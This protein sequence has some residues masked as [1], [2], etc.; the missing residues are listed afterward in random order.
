MKI[1]YLPALSAVVGVI[2]WNL[3][4]DSFSCFFI[5]SRKLHNDINGEKYSRYY[6]YNKRLKVNS[7]FFKGNEICKRGSEYNEIN[8]FMV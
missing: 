1:I 7:D 3:P 2:L 5:V 6:V 4:A 8:L